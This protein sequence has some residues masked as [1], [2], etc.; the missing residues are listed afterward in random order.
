MQHFIM[1]PPSTSVTLRDVA[2]RAGVNVATASRALNVQRRALVNEQT[3][4][5]V[6]AA[7]TAL[8]YQPNAIARGLKTNRSHTVG[9]LVPDLANP[10]YPPIV[11]GVEDV[12]IGY[13]YTPLI[14]NT[15]NDVARERR[16]FDALRERRVDGFVIA[17]ALREHPL[18]AE[19][20][21]AEVPFVLALRRIEGAP[22]WAVT[23]DEQQGTRDALEH[24]AALGHERIGH[25]A[26]PQ[27]MSPPHE[28]HLA[29]L[30]TGAQL[31]L[32]DTPELVAFGAA[33]SEEG[34]RRACAELLARTPRPTA[35]LAANDL[36]ALGCLDAVRDAGLRCPEDVSIVGFN[37]M[38][39]ADRMTP[40]ISA[41]RA[42]DASTCSSAL[43]PTPR[44]N[45][46]P[47][48]RRA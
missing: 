6:L 18:I 35:V 24:L 27:E 21:A 3:V 15:D 40:S 2:D 22:A 33:F 16:S 7:A 45:H 10:L 38:P 17:T 13:G 31:G 29:F 47:S 5:R 32:L 8:G 44:S 19:A 26:G 42:N 34:G 14:A 25:V 30:A 39:Y 28:R 46:H 20:L 4:Q 12:L 1:T 43:N 41:I 48:L 9:V 36:L 37:D 11:R 23:V